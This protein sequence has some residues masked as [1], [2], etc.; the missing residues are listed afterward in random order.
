[1]RWKSICD[2]TARDDFLA[3]DQPRTARKKWIL[4]HVKP[5]G[6]LFLDDGA[7]KALPNRARVSSPP[8]LFLR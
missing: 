7:C 1:M 4:A 5:K 3:T 6:T 8:V 2:G